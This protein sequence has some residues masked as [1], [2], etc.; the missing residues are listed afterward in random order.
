[1]EIAS[2]CD[3]VEVSGKTCSSASVE[4]TGIGFVGFFV[5]PS[6]KSLI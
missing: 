2:L 3:G 4:A 5:Y 1:M 6:A